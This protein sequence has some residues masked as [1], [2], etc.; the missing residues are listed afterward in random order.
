MMKR[1][2]Q[3]KSLVMKPAFRG[4]KMPDKKKYSRNCKH[5]KASARGGFFMFAGLFLYHRPGILV[6]MLPR[7]NQPVGRNNQRALRRSLIGK[8]HHPRCLL[9]PRLRVLNI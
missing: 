3:A 7:N 2:N 8:R 5:K 9:C 1:I 6:A 4:R